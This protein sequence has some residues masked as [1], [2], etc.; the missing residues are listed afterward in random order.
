MQKNK[1]E[2]K[3]NSM[4]KK[5]SLE[6]LDEAMEWL[7][8]ASE[9]EVERMRKIYKEETAKAEAAQADEHAIWNPR[10]SSDEFKELRD[11][12]C[13]YLDKKYQCEL[14]DYK[15]PK[16]EFEKD[17]EGFSQDF[18]GLLEIIISNMSMGNSH[19]LVLTYDEELEY[20]DKVLE[21]YKKDMD[22][23]N[24]LSYCLGMI[25]GIKSLIQAIGTYEWGLEKLREEF[26]NICVGETIYFFPCGTLCKATVSEVTEEGIR[27][28]NPLL[29]LS[30]IEDPFPFEKYLTRMFT[31]RHLP[32][33]LKYQWLKPNM[34]CSNCQGLH[35]K[36]CFYGYETE[37]FHDENGNVSY[38]CAEEFCA[39][40]ERFLNGRG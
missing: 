12:I 31:K 5:E 17:M 40:N 20:L 22:D 7:K 11:R 38:K 6:I 21:G 16:E 26:N 25:G 10:Y 8:N 9:E 39:Y 28:K 23:S 29:P 37:E 13:Y 36:E 27:L 15:Y 33:I 34:Q 1:E 19:A 24:K 14:E 30:W 2:R 4:G 18:A 3:D 35:L 32:W